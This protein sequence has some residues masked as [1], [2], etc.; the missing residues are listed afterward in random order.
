MSYKRVTRVPKVQMQAATMDLFRVCKNK[1]K[2]FD[3]FM[4]HWDWACIK[5]QTAEAPQMPVFEG[6]DKLCIKNL[7]QDA[8]E[9]IFNYWQTVDKNLQNAP[10]KTPQKDNQELTS[11]YPEV[12]HWLSN[13]PINNPCNNLPNNL[14]IQSNNPTLEEVDS[15]AR[16]NSLNVDS[17]AFYEHFN[18]NGWTDK[19][20]KPIKDW[21]A[22]IKSWGKGNRGFNGKSVHAQQYEQR[23]YTE[24]QLAALNDDPIIKALEAGSQNS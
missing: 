6:L 3:A 17:K 10:K 21:K 24:E 1:D 11:G 16:E 14:S 7:I 8:D 22:V 4:E 18:R 23:T 2:V 13:K 15:Y 12:N 9:S 20:G 19:E 5:D